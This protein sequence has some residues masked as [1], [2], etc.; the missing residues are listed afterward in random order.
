MLLDSI[1]VFTNKKE[2][3]ALLLGNSYNLGLNFIS[4]LNKHPKEWKTAIKY[5]QV[6][7]D[8]NYDNLTNKEVY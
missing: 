2:H 8:E 7:F 4:V 5:V 1:K 3:D 6:E